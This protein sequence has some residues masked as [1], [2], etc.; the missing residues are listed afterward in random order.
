MRVNRIHHQKNCTSSTEL[1]T[2]FLTLKQCYLGIRSLFAAV[3]HIAYVWEGFYVWKCPL[4]LDGT[5]LFK[6][7]SF[8]K[9]TSTLCH[10]AYSVTVRHSCTAKVAPCRNYMWTLCRLGCGMPFD[11]ARLKN[12]IDKLSV[13]SKE[14][15]R[16]MKSK[17][18]QNGISQFEKKIRQSSPVSFH[19]FCNLKKVCK[20]FFFHVD[21]IA[22]AA[23]AEQLLPRS[24]A[25]VCC[26]LLRGIEWTHLKIVYI[27][28]HFPYFH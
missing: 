28:Q 23:Y 3:A 9:G 1:S 12:L 18:F 10:A 21:A 11:A 17:G 15:K 6:F 8:S 13:S 5:I 20:K 24:K 19:S 26:I 27:V 25:A 2:C 22:L 4:D 16:H 14:A 7:F